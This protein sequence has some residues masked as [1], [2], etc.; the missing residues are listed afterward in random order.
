MHKFFTPKQPWPLGLVY[1]ISQGLPMLVWFT[2]PALV[3]RQKFL[4][5]SKLEFLI[6]MAEKLI[7]TSKVI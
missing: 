7:V 1:A 5:H 4:F 2:E 3:G 6:E